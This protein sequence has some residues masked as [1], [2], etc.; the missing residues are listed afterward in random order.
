MSLFLLNDLI[1]RSVTLPIDE[2]ESSLHHDLV[3]HFLYMFLS[4]SSSGQLLFT[5]HNL[6]LLGEREL[7]R[8][9]CIW[10]TDRKQDGSTELSSVWDYPVRK[11]HSI[12]SLYKKGFLG[13]KPYLGSIDIEV[14]NA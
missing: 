1:Q 9:D 4:N 8:R 11:E 5:T 3:K 14:P 10:I 13:G 12:E 2:L 6:S 7:A